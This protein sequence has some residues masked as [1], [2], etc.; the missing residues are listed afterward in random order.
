MAVGIRGATLAMIPAIVLLA[1]WSAAAHE[2]PA[3][4]DPAA[5]VFDFEPPE[6]G[7]YHLPEI[8]A[9]ADGAV[10]DTAGRARSLK[11][12][13]AGRIVLLSF[14]Y[15]G[16]EVECPLGTAA[17]YDVFYAS[18]E[19]PALA[20]ALKLVSLSFDPARDT[21]E[22]MASYGYAAAADAAGKCPWDFLTT[23]S[24]AALDPI[25]AGYGQSVSR[26]ARGDGPINHLL[27]VHLIDR[28]GRVRNIYGLEFLDPRLLLA[29]I[30]T[31]LL[32][33]QAEGH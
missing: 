3:T 10:L 14:I 16:C 6:P 20:G 8:R 21:P 13:M 24:R 30:R 22:A 1:G 29:D 4:P 9:A 7:S 26:T 27:R 28:R 15:T 18:A 31:L 2:A 19:D 17:L 33:E 5:H 12:L 11:A 25:L 32:E 23:R